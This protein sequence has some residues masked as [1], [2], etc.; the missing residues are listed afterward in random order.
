M[1]SVV[2]GQQA[3]EV[4]GSE[5]AALPSA[6]AAVAPAMPEAGEDPVAANRL[7]LVQHLQQQHSDN[8]PQQAARGAGGPMGAAGTS[9]ATRHAWEDWGLSV[10]A[11]VLCALIAGIVFRRMLIVGGVDVTSLM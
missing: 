2:L 4:S 6:P 8:A 9:F 3:H 7:R 5:A 1:C 11:G 10:V